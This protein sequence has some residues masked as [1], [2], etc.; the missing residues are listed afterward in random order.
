M[1]DH[2][3]RC[4]CKR[5]SPVHDCQHVRKRWPSLA[6]R[7]EKRTGK[8]STLYP[9]KPSPITTSSFL[10]LTIKALMINWDQL[11]QYTT[12]NLLPP[13]FPSTT[14]ETYITHLLTVVVILLICNANYIN[15][16]HRIIKVNMPVFLSQPALIDMTVG[17]CIFSTS[18]LSAAF[19]LTRADIEEEN[20]TRSIDECSSTVDVP[21]AIKLSVSTTKDQST[22]AR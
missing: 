15:H 9:I 4:T 22:I 10:S 8:A 20:C 17:L 18:L 6:K 7:K 14:V 11:L 2:T 5:Y 21:G 3:G 12:T 1:P 16:S 19:L 13:P